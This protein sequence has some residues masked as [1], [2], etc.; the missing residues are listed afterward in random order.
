MIRAFGDTVREVVVT[1]GGTVTALYAGLAH[2]SGK[3]V[4]IIDDVAVPRFDWLERLE[5]TFDD[6]TVGAVGGRDVVHHGGDIEEGWVP[7]VG[8]LTWYGKPVGNHHLG[9]GG[10]RDVDFLKGCNFAFRRDEFKIPMGL[11]GSGAQQS[12]DMA[13]CLEVRRL[14]S[15]VVY[16]PRIVVDHCPGERYDKNGRLHG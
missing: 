10:A 11:L 14:G 6:D 16:D 3:L 7:V 5:A 9:I 12:Q 4:A 1:E 2:V 13:S 15:R 8:R